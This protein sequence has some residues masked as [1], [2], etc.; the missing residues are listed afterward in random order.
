[1]RRFLALR[2]REYHEFWN[3]APS[4]TISAIRP[5]YGSFERIFGLSG[6]AL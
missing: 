6:T 2:A 1:M 5:L 3:N 4:F